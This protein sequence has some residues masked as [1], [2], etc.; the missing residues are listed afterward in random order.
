MGT[1]IYVERD[2]IYILLLCRNAKKYEQKDKDGD[3][4]G[5]AGKK[6]KAKDGQDPGSQSSSSKKRKDKNR[7]DEAKPKSKKPQKSKKM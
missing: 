7:E 5:P 2:F 4:L 6:P 3:E 1:K